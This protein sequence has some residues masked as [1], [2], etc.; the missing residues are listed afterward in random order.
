MKERP[1]MA[2]RND[3]TL[4]ESERPRVVSEARIM[5]PA[6]VILLGSTS[7]ISAL[8]LMRHMLTLKPRDQRRVA[9]VYIDTDDPPA[10]L[11]EFRKQNSS[12]FQ[13]F[14]LRIAVPA[15]ISDVSRIIH[16]DKEREEVRQYRDKTKKRSDLLLEQHTFIKNKVPQ[17]F[18]SGAGGIRNNGHVAACF[19]YSH[20][21]ETLD[22]ALV[23]IM[24]L[25]T[26]QDEAIVTEVQVDIVAFL[27]GGTGSGILPDV[28]VMMRDLLTNRQLKQRINLFC[29]LPEPIQGANLTDLS[30][31]KSNATACLLELI[32]YSCTVPKS[33][34]EVYTKYMRTKKNRLTN[35]PI[36]NEVY[37]V[38]HVA[39]GDAGDTARI[40]GLDLFHRIT[41][42]SGV[43]FLEHSKWVDRR[44]LG[45]V[46]NRGLPTMF[47]TSCPLEA[48]F[49][50]IEVATTFAQISAAHLLPLLASYQPRSVNPGDGDKRE[51]TRKWRGVV[52]FDST[53]NDPMAIKLSEFGRH[54]FEDATQD[55]LDRAWA[56]VD[57]LERAAEVRIKEVIAQKER[58]EEK[59]INAVP[60]ADDENSSS[61]LDQHIR[62]L[63]QLQQEYETALEDLTD[64]DKPRVPRRPTELEARLTR[65]LPLPL[66]GPLAD[67]G[68][69]HASAVCAAYN[70]HLRLHAR[71]V[72]HQ[73][74]ERMLRGLL[75]HIQ[76]A[77]RVSLSWFRSAE[78]NERAKALEQAG[79]ASMAWQGYLDY[80][81]PHQRHVFDLRSL[82]GQDG[83]S[84]ATE[85]LYRWANLGD[86]EVDEGVEIDYSHFIGPCIEYLS[87][88]RNTQ[89]DIGNLEEQV[90]GR[91]AD[92][93]VD[94][95]KAYYT[96][97]FQDMNLFELLDKA[98][99][100]SA[101]GQS[102]SQQISDYLLEHLK[103]IRGLMSSMIA[104]EAELWPE[105]L[106]RLDTSVYLGLHVRGSQQSILKQTLTN[107][108]PVTKRGQTPMIEPAIDP[109]RIQV[110]YGQHAISL[111]TIR[112]FYRKQNSAMEAYSLHQSAWKNP[113]GAAPMPV[114]SSGE[115]QRL[116]ETQRLVD[117]VIRD[118]DAD[119]FDFDDES[120]LE[121]FADADDDA[122]A[123][124]EHV[125]PALGDDM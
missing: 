48:R 55:Q 8:E 106:A 98:A 22:R 44:T 103:H 69:D 96:K 51:W 29:M 2:D 26:E 117:L 102:R 123:E 72:R 54:E 9:L 85:R 120:G 20:I 49:P 45:D 43:G 92:R 15:G 64:R 13:E 125:V 5:T 33:S 97:V 105:G 91:L 35:D 4:L 114:H 28:V 18:A 38:G 112:D 14:P 83:H 89:E 88:M 6:I 84:I 70:D 87:S 30:W 50:S 78:A 93:V 119:T 10:S 124:D 37:L 71:A 57:R 115:A 27:G 66:P 95:F 107:L 3:Q 12:T 74:L 108:G 75:N 21:Y 24:R 47:G 63:K 80:P 32:A 68:R 40:V 41:D 109:H 59:R 16:G 61:L 82:R 7:A 73:E 101:K 122:T 1:F 99:P 23:T 94:F 79:K 34:S 42:A 39:M 11:T 104:F 62:Y 46:D 121:T 31:R 90:A 36:A 65:R 77:L 25:G 86:K 111:S 110:V 58:E 113:K 52:R 56:K 67:L 60:P 116:V 76:D 118:P 100:P 19:G 17:Y 53:A 81:H